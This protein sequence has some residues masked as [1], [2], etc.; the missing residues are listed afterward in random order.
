MDGMA[1]T[2]TM[3]PPPAVGDNWDFADAHPHSLSGIHPYP[4]KF[5]PEIPRRLIEAYRPA[6][7]LVL[8]DP[9]CGSGTTLSPI[10]I[11]WLSWPSPD[12]SMT[13]RSARY[14][15]SSR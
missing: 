1:F 4:A 14:G 9:F 2:A 15:A 13:A 10:T 8:L 12:I 6:D 11:G 3:A 5:I 7:G